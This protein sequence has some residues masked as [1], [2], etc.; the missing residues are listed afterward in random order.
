MD[1]LADSGILLRL[2]EPADP[3]HHIVDQAVRSLHARGDHIVIAPQN[4]AEFWNVCTRPATARGGY[5]LSI[6]ET[7]RRLTIIEAVFAVLSEPSSAYRL[8]RTLVMTHAVQGKQVHDARLAALMQ[9]LGITHIL[10]LNGSDFFRY[11]GIIPIDPATL[12]PPPP[13]RPR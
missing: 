11:P 9:S 8:W 12:A 3:L 4:V 10:T 13:P 2:L 7:D 6:T 1:V 5:G